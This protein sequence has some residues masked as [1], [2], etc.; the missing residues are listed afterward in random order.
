M[1]EMMLIVTKELT[2]LTEDALFIREDI[3]QSNGYL[4]TANVD[5]TYQ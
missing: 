1:I 2:Y 4:T 3:I 5:S